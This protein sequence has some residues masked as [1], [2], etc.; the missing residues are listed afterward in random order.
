MISSLKDPITQACGELLPMFNIDYKVMCELP[1]K[2]LNSAEEINV[3]VGL[4]QGLKGS[5]VLGLTGEA[6]KGI[7]SGMMGGAEVKE[8]DAMGQSALSE[9]MNMLCGTTVSKIGSEEL[10]D[11]S[12]PTLISG[13]KVFMMT[14]A[15][16]IFFKMGDTKFNIAYSLE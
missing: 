15:K 11:I 5:I 16:K 2:S 12:P 13:E 3:I 1:E 10:I 4:T 7:V 6:A 14:S 8:I 9:F